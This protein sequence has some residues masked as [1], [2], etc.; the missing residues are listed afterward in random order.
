MNINTGRGKLE[1]QLTANHTAA[2]DV[3]RNDANEVA[4]GGG[5]GRRSPPE[6]RDEEK[7]G[8]V[9]WSSLPHRQQLIILTLARLSEPVVQTS[10]QAYMFYQLKSFDET[11]P[12]SSIAAQAGLL[13]SSFTAAQFL[14]AMIWGRISDS[15][16]GGRKLVLL[17]G[18]FG[19]AL[20]CL[21]FGFSKSF[22]Q[23]IFFRSLGGALNGNIGVMRTMVSEIVQEKKYQSRA[24]LLF[25]MCFNIGVIIGPI[26]G[27]VLANPATS[28][29]RLFGG[30]TFFKSYPYA[31]PNIVS[32]FFLACAGLA[33]FFGL[34][35]T[36]SSIRHHE[37]LGMKCSRKIAQLSRG[38]RSQSFSHAYTAVSGDERVFATDTEMAPATPTRL[39]RSKSLPKRRLKLPFR[40]IFTYNVVCTLVAHTL[41]AT[42]LGAFNSLWFV[43]LSTPVSDPAHPDPP[44]FVR[45]LPFRFTGGLGM[46]PRHVGFA[47][48]ILGIIGISMQL[49]IYP[50]VH[51]RLGVVKS[52]RVF[53]Y[54]FPVAY[55]LVPFLSTVPSTSPPPAEKDGLLVWLCLCSVLFIQVSGR[56]FA[57]PATTILVNNASPHPSVLG[58]MHGIGQSLSSAGRTF[59]PAAGGALYGLGLRCGVVGAVFW[60]LSGVALLGCVASNW[61]KEGDGHEIVL[62]GDEEAEAEAES[63]AAFV[64]RHALG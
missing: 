60:A 19:T 8:N 54:C 40:R 50:I 20:S 42:H 16:R 49:F 39:S 37:D 48:A 32:A 64:R 9:T 5:A 7:E 58:T 4:E 11:L 53:L 35:E 26:L 12:D 27:G 29:P 23:A 1:H 41:L 6:L 2:L 59:G 21:G 61:V 30:V 14:T 31:T 17:I 45:N 28:Y 13:S 57:L 25:P 24:F 43:F 15:E 47:M 62:D 56:T 34:A 18:L 46:Q 36:L 55:I 44:S 51:A 63:Q 52:W 22:Y 38:R 3:S 10:L 33:V